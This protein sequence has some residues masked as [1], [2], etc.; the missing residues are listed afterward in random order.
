[1]QI[2]I[3]I[4]VQKQ[5]FFR[6]VGHKNLAKFIGKLMKKLIFNKVAIPRLDTFLKESLYKVICSYVL[7]D[8]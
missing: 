8:M 1:M 6:R 7:Y 5:P 3:I 2:N 4:W